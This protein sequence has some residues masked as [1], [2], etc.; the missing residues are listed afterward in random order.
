[1]S[2]L[3]RPTK[4]SKKFFGN[5][6]LL[7]GIMSRNS[8]GV[9]TDTGEKQ[10]LG[11]FTKERFH[12]SKQIFRGAAWS[13]SK[14]Q[15]NLGNISQEELDKLV[16]ACQLYDKNDQLITTANRSRFNDPFFS[17]LDYKII[18]DEGEQELDIE[19]NPLHKLLYLGL[20]ERTTFKA[21]DGSP[22]ISSRVKYELID[23]ESQLNSTNNDIDLWTEVGSLMKSLSEEK[24]KKIAVIMNIGVSE[25]TSH[26][27][28]KSSLGKVLMEQNKLVPNTSQT[29]QQYFV[30]LATSDTELF[31]VQYIIAAAIKK[32][33]IRRKRDQGWLYNGKPIATVE[34]QIREYFTDS[35]NQE[36]LFELQKLIGDP[37]KDST[38]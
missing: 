35:N 20:K 31:N 19:N 29:Y 34:S 37:S 6:R 8:Q 13:D 24:L 17:H 30:E 32:G 9:L 12:G 15:Y 18:A 38:S 16:A 36:D 10:E 28:A 25:D 27:L 26:S 22:V 33:Y 21:S 11:D 4:N 7:Q 14:R 2:I 3:I 23:K 1:M 5:A